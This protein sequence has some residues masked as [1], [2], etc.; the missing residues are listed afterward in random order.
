M[1]ATPSPP[2][3]SSTTSSTGAPT[4]TAR[5]MT[6][7]ELAAS[8]GLKKTEQLIEWCK[9]VG[10]ELP[11]RKHLLTPATVALIVERI[12]APTITISASRM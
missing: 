1:S 8:Y 6:K 3:T 9:S 11:K 10:I 2:N 5:T 12:G 7:G 4:F